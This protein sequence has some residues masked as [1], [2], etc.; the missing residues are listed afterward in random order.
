MTTDN[1]KWNASWGRQYKM[2]EYERCRNWQKVNHFAG[3]FLMGRKD[4]LH[5]R[6]AE[7]RA[8]VG[9][10]A[11][12]YPESYLLPPER[13]AL[14]SR[15]PE[16]RTW[17]IK[18]SASSRGRGILLVNSEDSPPPTSAGVVQVYIAR[19]FL[20]TGRK[21]DIRLYAFVSSLFPLRIYMFREGL[22]RF[23]T[24]PYDPDGP[25][26]DL[27]MHLTNF[28]L[29][30]KD[31]AFVRSTDSV[32]DSK[33]RFTFWLDFMQK[34]GFDANRFLAEFEKLTITTIIAGVCEIR[35][36]HSRVIPH[37]HTSY[38]L[39]GIDIM[40]DADMEAHLIEIN[41]SPS[42]SGM[43]SKLDHDI[44]FPLNLD[45]LRMARIV[46]CDPTADDPCPNLTIV[47]ERYGQSITPER[48]K[49]V[50]AE[51]I[52]PWDSP[53]FADF[54]MVRDYLEE[55]TIKTDFRLIYPKVEN[56][57][58]YEPCFDRMC[59]HDIVFNTWVMMPDPA[60]ADVLKRHWQKHQKEV[61]QMTDDLF[62][63]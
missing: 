32:D 42:L 15:W 9:A 48:V 54:T 52:D 5:K 47:D 31:E 7:L 23:C 27:Q 59:Y 4:E 12:Y 25:P 36:T 6:M 40:L 35:K 8:R 60:K 63:G 16:V 19:P 50:E 56:I 33:W 14:T 21:F 55:S 18:P 58:E 39:Y 2:E 49:A 28:S 41:I 61:E 37:R 53:V 1:R 20:I 46:E 26:D 10:F 38:E 22:A 29:N 57:K 62:S 3:A 34:E 30:Q 11:A 17:I 24:H 51:G 45:V 43:D 13:A 44:K